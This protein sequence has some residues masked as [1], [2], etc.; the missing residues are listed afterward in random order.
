MEPGQEP[1][2]PK[3]TIFAPS[4]KEIEEKQAAT[5]VCLAK[6]FIPD[7]VSISWYLHDTEITEGVKTEEFSRYHNETK[8]YSLTSRLRVSKQKWQDSYN[9]F[10]CKVKFYV[11]DK[12]D[13]YGS[14][15]SSE[16]EWNVD[17]LC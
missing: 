13:V 14:V 6:D 5:L 2:P 17:K 11:N 3:V 1:T 9:Q 12:S 10:E 16:G 7:H 8:S 4:Q 15:I